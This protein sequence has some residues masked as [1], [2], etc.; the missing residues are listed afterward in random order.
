MFVIT[1]NLL[2]NDFKIIIVLYFYLSNKDPKKIQLINYNIY[3]NSKL[4]KVDNRYFWEIVHNSKEKK[5]II[6]NSNIQTK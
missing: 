4:S 6:V 3:Q 1:L 2:Y 5:I